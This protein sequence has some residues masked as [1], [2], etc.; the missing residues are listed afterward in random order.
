MASK[1][2][3]FAESKYRRGTILGLTVAEIFIL[4]LFLLMLVFLV[5]NQEQQAREQEQAQELAE[6]NNFRETWE[7]SLTGIETPDEI[8]ALRRWRENVSSTEGNASEELMRLL[9][10][11]EQER[12]VAE[13]ERQEVTRENEQLMAESEQRQ[14]ELSEKTQQLEQLQEENEQFRQVAEERRILLEKGQNPPCWYELVDNGEGGQREKGLYIFDIGVFDQ[15]MVVR[16]RPVPLGGAFDDSDRTYAEEAA[17]LPLER[18]RFNVP[19][20]DE[21]FSEDLGPIFEAGKQ[22]RVRTYSCIFYV[23]VWDHTS[24]FAKERWQQAH[25]RV[26]EGLFGTFQVRDEPWEQP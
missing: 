9:V 15:H 8:V 2:R 1:A 19:L 4:L 23:R 22:K 12:D 14:E 7:Q 3:N 21:E 25:D 24:E 5:L 17:L 10:E 18:I 26:L 13:S 20:I 16:R 6:L 11:A